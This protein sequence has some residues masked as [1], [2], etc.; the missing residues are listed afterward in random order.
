MLKR[1]LSFSFPSKRES[2]HK[3]QNMHVSTILK[4][5]I[6]IKW[7]TRGNL[8]HLSCISL[9]CRVLLSKSSSIFSESLLLFHP[10]QDLKQNTDTHKWRKIIKITERRIIMKETW[11]IAV[12]CSCLSARACCSSATSC[13]NCSTCASM[14]FPKQIDI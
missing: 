7:L 14:Q 11:S 8:E 1:I 9:C 12:S 4:D 6:N 10:H 13:S 5:C 2:Y 3:S